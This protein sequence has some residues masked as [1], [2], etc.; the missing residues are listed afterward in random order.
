M[1]QEAI[2]KRKLRFI[3]SHHYQ[4]RQHELPLPVLLSVHCQNCRIGFCEYSIE[5]YR[6][7]QGCSMYRPLRDNGGSDTLLGAV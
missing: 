1:S 2:K 7:P 5:N 6:H 3:T 4:K